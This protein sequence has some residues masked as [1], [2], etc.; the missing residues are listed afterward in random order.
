MKT[1]WLKRTKTY[2]KYVKNLVRRR[3]PIVGRR[4]A[5]PNA[6]NLGMT[7]FVVHT[8]RCQGACA[9]D[10]K[11]D[12]WFLG[13]ADLGEQHRRYC[14]CF[15]RGKRPFKV[16]KVIFINVSYLTILICWW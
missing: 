3:N 9:V 2:L 10:G 4:D 6:P 12:I 16:Y 14:M 8:W 1:F 5:H 13:T 7:C 11:C 15:M